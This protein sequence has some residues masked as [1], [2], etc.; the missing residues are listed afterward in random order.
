MKLNGEWP[1]NQSSYLAHVIAMNPI[2]E[3]FSLDIE[4]NLLKDNTACQL[5]EKADT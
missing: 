4:T 5:N 3:F 1:K 2:A